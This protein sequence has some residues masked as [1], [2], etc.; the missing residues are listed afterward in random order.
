MTV[1]R[2]KD[3]SDRFT[4]RIDD[5]IEMYSVTHYGDWDITQLRPGLVGDRPFRTKGHLHTDGSFEIYRCIEGLC[6]LVQIE[7]DGTHHEKI[8]RPDDREYIL[9]YA[10]HFVE[11]IG[12]KMCIFVTF[13]EMGVKKD[14]TMRG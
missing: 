9:P 11:N 14:Y 1:T 5:E 3:L 10:Y 7:K 6:R 4:D 13:G 8:L 12:D 2:F